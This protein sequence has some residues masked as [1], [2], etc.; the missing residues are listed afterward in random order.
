MIV[1][2]CFLF[3]LDNTRPYFSNRSYLLNVSNQMSRPVVLDLRKAVGDQQDSIDKL[4]F[5]INTNINSTDYILGK[6]RLLQL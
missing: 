5:D 6:Y 1:C 4:R 3:I 2:Y